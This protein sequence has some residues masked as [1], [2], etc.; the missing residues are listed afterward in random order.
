M[1]P[2]FTPFTAALAVS[3]YMIHHR[4][5]LPESDRVEEWSRLRLSLKSL[6]AGIAR[7]HR[8]IEEQVRLVETASI[9]SLKVQSG[10]GKAG[11]RTGDSRE[12]DRHLPCIGWGPK[13]AEGGGPVL[14]LPLN[15]ERRRREEEKEIMSVSR[16]FRFDSNWF[17]LI[18]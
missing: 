17:G 5:C 13:T 10:R 14:P 16:S 4:I 7:L 2:T 6:I 12:A 9:A 3:S 1:S 18:Q 15:E 11:K 8:K